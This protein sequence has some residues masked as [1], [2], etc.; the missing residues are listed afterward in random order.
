MTRHR[1]TPLFTALILLALAAPAARAAGIE[2]ALSPHLQYVGAGSGFDVELEVTSAGPA[3]NAFEAVLQ[4]DP[5]VLTFVPTAPTSLQQG[6]AM[7]GAC[8]SLFHLFQAS[9][10]SLSMTSSLLC[11]GVSITGPG[12]IYK[13]HF[14]AANTPGV[15]TTIHIR[16]SAFY[17]AGVRVTPVT[18]LDDTIFIDNPVG[19][20]PGV[21]GAS[22]ALR[23]APNPS[24]SGTTLAR[25]LAGRRRAEPARAGRRGA[26]R[27]ASRERRFRGGSARGGVGSQGRRGQER[28]A[29][30]V[31]G[32]LPHAR[33]DAADARGVPALVGYG[34]QASMPAGAGSG[35]RHVTQTRRNARSPRSSMPGLRYPSRTG[36][37]RKRSVLRYFLLSSGKT[38]T[39]IAS[40][41]ER[42]L[43]HERAEEVRAA[44][45]SPRPR[46]SVGRE[47]LR[48]E[49]R[50]PV[51]DRQDRVELTE[52]ARSAG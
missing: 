45:R 1:T 48:H 26:D 18:A 50:V 28:A 3:F 9:A 25:R 15:E 29:G 16:S 19:V 33:R 14:T 27:A 43:R 40:P 49:D 34:I 35:K 8:G 42:V 30:R 11:N 2:L 38:V 51:V 37:S 36:S 32:P 22:I 4:Y 46:P 52:V 23:A 5:A 7:T 13:L 20:A 21:G 17:N 24:V 44:T 47:L 41:P 12:T 6:S 39:T 31:P 10:D